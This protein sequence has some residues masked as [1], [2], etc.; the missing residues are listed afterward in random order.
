[1]DQHVLDRSALL[2]HCRQDRAFAAQLTRTFL[3]LLP[4]YRAAVQQAARDA[5][6][7][8]LR[9][10]AHR[11]KGALTTLYAQAA[12]EAAGILEQAATDGEELEP[13]LATLEHELQRL[14]DEAEA[15]LEWLD[16]GK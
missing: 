15:F 3:H 7:D 1:M 14:Q 5:N 16:S 4:D 10:H 8:A 13:Q 12:A 11:L 6:R 9:Y 2:D